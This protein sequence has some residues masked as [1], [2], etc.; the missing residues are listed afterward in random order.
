MAKILE[1]QDL[2]KAFGGLLA[3]S[4]LD[5][6]VG[7]GE[8]VGLIGPN[9]A[10]KTTFFNL[11]SGVYRPT[12]GN[13]YLRGEA[14][15]GL[16]PDAIAARGLVR[17]FQHTVL[18]ANLTV[19]ENALVATHLHSGLAF[20]PALLS[21]G[22]HREREKKA[23]ERARELLSFIGLDNIREEV[24]SNLP[25]GHQRLLGVAI[26]LAANPHVLLL[27]EPMTGM[28]QEETQ[29]MMDLIRKISQSGITILLV[30]HNMKAVM[31]ICSRVM[32]INFGRK[33]AEGSPAEVSH[34]EAVIQAYLGT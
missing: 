23:R 9:G 8:L 1:I 20:W 33:I 11:V 25:H 3:I 28:N 13:I 32:V 19:L 14:I 24:A 17:T 22:R 31:G 21:T 29:S 30:E 12:R 26:A 34:D 5:L 4:D 6:A 27:D 15:T 16:R 18:F 10:G 2:T 7:E